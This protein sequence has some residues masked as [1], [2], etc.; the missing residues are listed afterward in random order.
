MDIWIRDNL[1]FWANKDTKDTVFILSNDDEGADDAVDD[2][3]GDD[4]EGLYRHACITR[5]FPWP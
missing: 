5:F 3:N 1:V 4:D 2:Y